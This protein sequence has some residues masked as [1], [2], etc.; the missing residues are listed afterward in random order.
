VE[1]GGLFAFNLGV[2]RTVD[3]PIPQGLLDKAK[4]AVRGALRK[5]F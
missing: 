4:S 2:S 3:V 1:E 5:M